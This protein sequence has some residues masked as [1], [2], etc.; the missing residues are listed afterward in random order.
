MVVCANDEI[1]LGVLEVAGSLGLAVPGDVAVT[2]WDDVMAARWAG[3]TTVRQP[4]REL[5][6]LAAR[7]LD[8]RIRG[9]T[10]TLRR[11]LLPTQLLIRTTCGQHPEHHPEE[12]R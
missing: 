9:S 12:D 3:L 1:A 8:T 7:V 11:E 4:M 10:E 2:G 5:G 6:S